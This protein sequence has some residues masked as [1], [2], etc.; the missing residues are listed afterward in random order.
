MKFKLWL[1]YKKNKLIFIAMGIIIF[2]LMINF[3]TKF[4]W[5]L[6]LAFMLIGI[7]S[8]LLNRS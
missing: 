1:R 6:I 8:Y 4:L 5:I 7:G 2:V 3:G